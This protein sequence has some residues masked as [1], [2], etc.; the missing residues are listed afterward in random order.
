M[1]AGKYFLIPWKILIW[2]LCLRLLFLVLHRPE[3][4]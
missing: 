2:W 1:S 3:F 4:F